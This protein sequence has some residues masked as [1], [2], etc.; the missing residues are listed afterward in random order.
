M[1]KFEFGM[2]ALC[3]LIGGYFGS[4]FGTAIAIAVC[5]TVSGIVEELRK[6]KSPKVNEKKEVKAHA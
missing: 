1:K 5:M 2:F 6:D 3:V 4:V